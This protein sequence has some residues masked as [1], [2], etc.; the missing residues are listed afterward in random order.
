MGLD[1]CVAFRGDITP[2]QTDQLRTYLLECG[3]TRDTVYISTDGGWTE[4]S[5]FDRYYDEG[6]PRGWWPSIYQLIK[7]VQGFANGRDVVYHSD[8]CD[9]WD[10][11]PE[12][13]AEHRL[14]ALWTHFLSNRVNQTPPLPAWE[15][16]VTTDAVTPTDRTVVTTTVTE[17]EYWSRE[18]YVYRPGKV[19]RQ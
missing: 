15:R 18:A 8:A 4:I 1:V 12:S 13:A 7:A 17:T 10:A 14:Q 9:P 6:Y 5:V 3:G 16:R 19:R 2:E 11:D